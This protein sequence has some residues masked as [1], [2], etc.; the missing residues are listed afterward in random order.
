MEQTQTQL[1]EWLLNQ[2]RR[3]KYIR[4]PWLNQWREIMS[5]INPLDE[6]ADPTF[7]YTGDVAMSRS[8]QVRSQKYKSTLGS[9]VRNSATILNNQL[10]DPSVKWFAL[11][12]NKSTLK[13]INEHHAVKEWRRDLEDYIYWLCGNTKSN[14]Y[15]SSQAFI[16][17]WFTLGTAC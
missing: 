11:E 4:R 15:T 7:P 3:A 17:D 12:I 1:V 10:L 8:Q 9:L 16:W 14:F 6:N 2:T 13:E 5:Y